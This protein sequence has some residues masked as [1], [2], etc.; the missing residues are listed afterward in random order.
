MNGNVPSSSTSKIREL[1]ING[2]EKPTDFVGADFG[3]RSTIQTPLQ[4]VIP[5]DKAKI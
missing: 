5:T 1:V 4:L 2:I 3:R